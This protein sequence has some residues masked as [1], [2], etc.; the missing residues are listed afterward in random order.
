MIWRCLG[1]SI[2]LTTPVV[3]GVLNVTPDSFSD[4]GRF[5]DPARALDRAAAM[6]AGG[7][8]IID[9]GGES[10]RPGAA[11][12][13]A[14]AEIE[15]VVPVIERIART[16]DVAI[17]VDTSKCAV[18]SAAVAAGACI[19]N[20]VAALQ[21]TGAPELA[22]RLGAGV[23]LMHMQGDPRTMQL[24]PHYQDVVAEV[25]AFLVAR[26]A[27]LIAAGADP[28]A[29]VVDP[30]IGFGKTLT[31]NLTLLR[32]LPRLAALGSPLLLG[33]SRKSFIGHVLGAGVDDR[34]QGG[35]GL[36]AWAVGQGVSVIRTHDVDATVEA[37]R[38]VGAVLRVQ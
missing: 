5:T 4:G 29:I 9:V 34:M 30:G 16:L 14:E 19:V 26:R 38:M 24:A 2:D 18:M 7:A 36:A 1:R 33:V 23:C 22:A 35:V 12:V 25:A 3:M 31:H 8:A 15:R 21:A 20:D 11:A 27:V 13:D 6:L 28:A 17:S 32:H 37:V 10:T